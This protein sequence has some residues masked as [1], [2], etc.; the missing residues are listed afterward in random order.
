M[1][2]GG[3]PYAVLHTALY[4]NILT[5]EQTFRHHRDFRNQNQRFCSHL[6]HNDNNTNN[7]N[8]TAM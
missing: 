3:T 8:D 2:F 6:K 4:T 7:G 5:Y 1:R